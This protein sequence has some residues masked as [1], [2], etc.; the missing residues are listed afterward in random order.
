MSADYT[1][2]EDPVGLFCLPDTTANTITV[3]MKDILIRCSLP[4]N[5]CKGQ[6]YDGAANMQGK[7]K[8]VATQIRRECPAAVPVHCMA[9]SLNL[10]LQDAG[11]QITLLRNALSSIQ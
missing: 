7:R 6:A 5:H 4:L 1:V 9:H 11:R 3:V 10:C 2:N 8:G